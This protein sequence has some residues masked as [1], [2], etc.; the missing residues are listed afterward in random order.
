MWK[1][2]MMQNEI[3]NQKKKQYFENCYN[4]KTRKFDFTC[5]C[6]IFRELN[7]KQLWVFNMHQLKCRICGDIITE[8]K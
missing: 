7:Y 2:H 4:K 1:L 8:E 6:G 3:E 5:S